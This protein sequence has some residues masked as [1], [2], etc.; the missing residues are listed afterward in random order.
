MDMIGD[1]MMHHNEDFLDNVIIKNLFEILITAFQTLG[2]YS[3]FEGNEEKKRWFD[4]TFSLKRHIKHTK[5]IEM[6]QEDIWQYMRTLPSI[7]FQAVRRKE[8]QLAYLIASMTRNGSIPTQ[9]AV[10]PPGRVIQLVNK[11]AREGIG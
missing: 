1:S 4:K 10:N 8:N 5:D 6:V 2:F 3:D 11:E 9:W 7:L